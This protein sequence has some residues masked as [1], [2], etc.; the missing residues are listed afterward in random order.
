MESSNVQHHNAVAINASVSHVNVGDISFP[1]ATSA[2]IP[3]AQARPTQ[4]QTQTQAEDDDEDAEGGQ[5]DNK[6]SHRSCVFRSKRGIIA[7][8]KCWVSD[9]DKEMH[10]E[11]YRGLVLEK[12]KIKHFCTDDVDYLTAVVCGKKHHD[13][14]LRSFMLSGA[15]PDA[16][17]NIPWN[18]DGKNGKDDPNHSESIVVEWLSNQ[19]NFQRFK[20]DDVTGKKKIAVCG[21][22]SDMLKARGIRKE[23]NARSVLQKINNM[24]TSWRETYQWTE[25][26]GQGVLE[27]EGSESFRAKVL[28]RCSFFYDLED[29][30]KDRAGTRPIASSDDLFNDSCEDADEAEDEDEE[31][32]GGGG[33]S[34]A[35]RKQ[36]PAI[37]TSTSSSDSV[38][39][40]GTSATAQSAA[41]KR[42]T[43]P[44]ASFN[45]IMSTT[46]E[47]TMCAIERNKADLESK[48]WNEGQKER[49][50]E[51]NMRL[52]RNYRE[53]REQGWEDSFIVNMFPAM[54]KIVDCKSGTP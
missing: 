47:E 36:P 25:N 26:T 34:Q 40:S 33:A 53:L 46:L 37:E 23:R 50:M 31:G 10:Y 35:K 28:Q 1:G 14:A 15:D 22:I 32:E 48:K 18:K 45:E 7:K 38:T 27:S 24:I 41:K 29:V 11:C 21:E 17:Q 9:C 6:C 54:Q 30:L 8:Y 52:L 2:Q 43:K 16:T 12:N 49:D 20:G 42:K 3:I 39:G 51:F 5:V 13:K 4:T 44:S 19:S